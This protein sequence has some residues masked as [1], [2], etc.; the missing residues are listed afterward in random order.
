MNNY[1][2]HN[3]V[4][5]TIYRGQNVE[6]LM[7]QQLRN[8]YTTGRWYAFPNALEIGRPI[9][10]GERGTLINAPYGSKFHVFNE[11]QLEE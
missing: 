2:P 3:P 9:R 11:D 7:S 1:R 5:G 4:T 10:R 6:I 8:G